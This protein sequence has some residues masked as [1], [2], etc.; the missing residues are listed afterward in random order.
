M[1]IGKLGVWGVTEGMKAADAAAFAARVERWGYGALWLPEAV[2]RNVLVH[3]ALLLAKTERLVIGTGIA[4]IYARDPIAMAAGQL[5]L[6]EQSDGRFLLGIGVSHTDLV[7]GLRGHQYEKPIEKMRAYLTGM[8][9]AMYI[10]PRPAEKPPTLIA[11]LGPRMLALA[12]EMADGVHPYNVT[13]AHTAQARAILGPGKLLCPEQ[14]VL[15]ET[16]PAA[17][18]A[19]ARN[20]LSV[21]LPRPNY[22]NNFRRMGFTD[23]DLAGGGSDRL[24]DAIVAWGDEAAIRRRI[25]EHWDA[26][27]DHV[28]IQAIP[29]GESM[30]APPDERL[31]ALLAP[32]AG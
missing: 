28:C 23:A 4:N 18:R 2:G 25:Q 12:A 29:R 14:M 27:A 13:P 7:E 11:A 19:I 21:Y 5:T 9:A 24:V 6:A 8:G 16:D 26:G 32:A 1:Q 10:A 22:A 17:A 3:S 30:Q 31:L 15:L 20:V